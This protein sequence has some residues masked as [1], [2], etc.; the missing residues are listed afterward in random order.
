MSAGILSHKVLLLSRSF[1]PAHMK[2]SVTIQGLLEEHSD[3]PLSIATLLE[4]TGEQ[5]FG[6][7]SGLLTL[8]MLIP[9]PIPLAGFSTLM[10]AGTILMGLQLALGAKQPW[11]PHRLAQLE[12]SP[13]L[14]Q[15]LLKNI[16]RVLYPVEKFSQ[17]RL[18]RV[19]H[20]RNIRRLVGLCMAWNA[21][22]MALPL[23]IPL[24]NL[25]PAYTIEALVIGLLE[26]D[27][28]LML[29]GLGM[30]ALTTVFFVSI[31]GAMWIIFCQ[32]IEYFHKLF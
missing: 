19:S 30:T 1:I 7:L 25:L 27:G 32:A 4:R 26:D 10:G 18:V 8:P 12:M 13:K 22:L 21:T 24:T 16:E 3:T 23:P 29:I 20:N 2:L 6:I 31:T 14:S 5:G 9:V 17:M 15:G 11:L 28:L